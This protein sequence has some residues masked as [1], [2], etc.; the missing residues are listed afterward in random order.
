MNCDFCGSPR[1]TMVRAPGKDH[2]WSWA[3]ASCLKDPPLMLRVI[4]G[5]SKT[6]GPPAQD[7]DADVSWVRS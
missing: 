4:L 2:D 5:A 7:E 6:K 3:C 1:A